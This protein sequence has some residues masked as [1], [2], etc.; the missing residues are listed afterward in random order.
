VTDY[1]IIIIGARIAGSV[2]A[3]HLGDRGHRALLLD[4]NTFPSDTLS[5][6]FFRAPALRA[7]D[8]IGV[9]D[10]VEASAPRLTV[11]YNVVDDI[12]FPEPVDEPDDYPYYLCVRRIA[13]D[14]ILVRRAQG[15]EGIEMREGAVATG[16]L[17]DDGRC[18][19]VTWKEK[20]DRF[21]ARARAVI[22]ADGVHSTVA[23]KVEPKVEDERPVERTMYYAYYR[24][25]PPKE[26]PAAEFHFLGDQLA[27]CIPTNDD[28]T[29][30]AASLP[31]EEFGR[32]RSDPEGTLMSVL[33]SMTALAPRLTEA[34]REGPVRG[35]GSIPCFRRVPY[36]HGWA[37]VGD[38]GMTLDPWSG[39]GIDQAST[40][41]TI[42][43][44]QLDA[45]LTEESDWESAMEAYH[46]A[47]NEFSQKAYRR[48]ADFAPDLRPMTQKALERRGLA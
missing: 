24:G 11:D 2:L 45:F 4:R 33:E 14:H 7:F 8:A 42:L 25:I 39:Q 18:V 41:A 30:L 40:H 19:G 31:I 29:L 10:E 35:T 48:T 16:L 36:G 38:A 26:G 37:L 34:E 6:H 3:S 12:V 43:A 13:L 9:L 17:W 22:G 46:Q 15:T 20:D 23:R 32:F 47:R 5:T 27:Y 21:E 28:L 1:D 44:D